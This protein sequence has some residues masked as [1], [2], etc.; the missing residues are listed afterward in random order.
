MNNSNETRTKT[1][2]YGNDSLEIVYRK[3]QPL[4]TQNFGIEFQTP[5]KIEFKPG[6]TILGKGTAFFNNSLPLPCDI[7]WERDV[8]VKM[9]D[10]I[11][12]FA[13]IFRPVGNNPIPVIL[14]WSPYGKTV[15]QKAP[16]GVAPSAVSGLQ[17]F[18]GADPAYWCN[19]GYA[20]I[21]VDSRGSFYSEGDI[22]FWGTPAADDCYD[23]IEWTAGQKWCNGKVAMSGNSW[24]GIIQWFAASQNPPH[25]A[26]IAP[27][28]GHIDLYRY[29]VLRG[30]ITDVGFSNFNTSTQIGQNFVEDMAAMALRYPLMNGYWKDKRPRLEEIK[31]PAYI[32]ASWGGH[33]TIDAFRRVASKDKW[34]RV[35]NTG[36]WP[37]YYE[38]ADDLRR[39]YE[40]FL[41][42]IDNGWEKTPRVRL[43]VLNPGGI[44]QVNRPENEWPLART[45][46]RKLYLD[47]SNN[48]LAA[49]APV[50][51][52]FVSYQ[53]DD[54]RG[55]TSF[56]IDFKQAA[57]FIGYVSL[58]LYIEA[59]SAQD[60]DIF[61]LL[62]KL[63]AAGKPVP[64]GY[65]FVGPDGRL[66]ASHRA[67]DAKQS[68][69][70]PYHPHDKEELLEPQQIVPLDIEIRPIGM[71][72]QAGEKL[73]LS[74]AGYNLL[75]KFR[76][77][78][79][80]GGGIL[81]GPAVRNKGN[82]VIHTGGRYSS[83][84]LM[85]QIS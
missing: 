36:E 62:N 12:L 69:P 48:T 30:G 54:N 46:Y 53:S 52:A 11:T 78:P 55:E 7:L 51:E 50:K 44:D 47:A 60:A 3:A 4:N 14:S 19:H 26:A 29:D 68:N 79:V 83:Y 1:R 73:C 5:S 72:W 84:L 21:N 23:F 39:F 41:K 58:R 16:P 31:M 56:I 28:E 13:D 17:K 66:R 77:G 80:P 15:P 6:S 64:G 76:K 20:I 82:H 9:R 10:G 42:G 33:Q 40:H 59:A 38:Y 65:G 67:F 25:L 75:S 81:A 43:S 70:F 32:V 63:D 45:Q 49:E 74:L 57:E 18:E 22:E 24:L 34:L 35:H 2:K 8:A 85:P 37:D 61:V 27:W 71:R